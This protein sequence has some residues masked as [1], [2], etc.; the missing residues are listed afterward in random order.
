M[1]ISHL[2]NLAYCNERTGVRDQHKLYIASPMI[3]SNFLTSV[4]KIE[5]KKKKLL[6]N[7]LAECMYYGQF[8]SRHVWSDFI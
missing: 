5:I 1:C 4:F 6:F 7:F 8:K 2:R 3:Y